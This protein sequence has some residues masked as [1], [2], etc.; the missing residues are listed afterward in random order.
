MKKKLFFIAL[1]VL[2][3]VGFAKVAMATQHD[4]IN[5]PSSITVDSEGCIS[6]VFI[7]EEDGHV[8]GTI[9]LNSNCTF[10]LVDPTDGYVTTTTGTYSIDGNLSRG[11]MADLTFYVDG[12]SAG[13]VTIAWP[14]NEG[15]CI[16]MNGFVFRKQ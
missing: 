9:T 11:Q 14:E 5:H 3:S 15:I 12:R 16:Y 6:G 4:E 10:K 2:L 8:V 7:A 1:S 13:T